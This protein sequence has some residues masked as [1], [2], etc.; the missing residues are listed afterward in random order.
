MSAK[1]TIRGPARVMSVTSRNTGTAGAC[2]EADFEKNFTAVPVATINNRSELVQ[3]FNGI[4]DGLN[5]S[6][7]DWEK[8]VL[9]LKKLRSLINCEAHLMP[10]F[11]A[12]VLS[13]LVIP[14][15]RAMKDL[16]SQVVREAAYTISL[17]CKVFGHKMLR[18][19]EDTF[20]SLLNVVQS[21]AKVMSSSAVILLT[22]IGSYI[23]S[24][25][26][27]TH[28]NVA[29]LHKSREI[30]RA[31]SVMFQ[32]IVE[33]WDSAILVK[34]MGE[35]SSILTRGLNDADPEVRQNARDTFVLFEESYKEVAGRIFKTLDSAKQK[36]MTGRLT[37]S[38]ST[39]S[40]T[41]TIK[42]AARTGIPVSKASSGYG[43]A[44]SEIDAASVRRAI[45]NSTIKTTTL[46]P[47]LPT[48]RLIQP[49]SPAI[50]TP[51]FSHRKPTFSREKSSDLNNLNMKGLSLSSNGEG[52]S[53]IRLSNEASRL[54]QPK[55]T[56]ISSM[57]ISQRKPTHQ[58]SMTR[59]SSSDLN[60]GAYG[61]NRSPY[62]AGRLSQGKTSG[63]SSTHFS[64]RKPTYQV[65]GRESSYDLNGGSSSSTIS[66]NGDGG[67]STTKFSYESAAAFEKDLHE[68]DRVISAIIEDLMPDNS[69]GNKAA[70]AKGLETLAKDNVFKKWDD[71]FKTILLLLVKNFDTTDDTTLMNIAGAFKELVNKQPSRFNDYI[72]LVTK[73]IVAIKGRSERNSKAIDLCAA[74]MAK[75]L[76]A[77]RL[78]NI[79]NTIVD[80]E[81]D[82]YQ[83]SNALKMLAKVFE[84]LPRKDA[85]AFLGTSFPLIVKSYKHPVSTVRRATVLSLVT[86]IRKVER[87]NVEPYLQGL[88]KSQLRLLDVYLEK[89]DSR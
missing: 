80:T 87:V 4:M 8:R 76:E 29:A 3:Y 32:K 52:F 86:I 75:Q 72:E 37:S 84:Y 44:A 85:L 51:H 50:T 49:K 89:I 30:R 23:E 17:Y 41:E 27:L 42:S 1:T 16:R 21:S 81:T 58:Q 39:R 56:P 38:S 82:E 43:R 61:D 40:I 5:A 53:A 2:T 13:K 33:N 63:S 6:D 14:L 62:D 28:M 66:T 65:N 12:E 47:Q 68:Q 77:P 45:K 60:G 10:E 78:L 19:I 71:H 11:D 88:D 48:S 73:A 57:Y 22:Y 20:E 34:Q 46:R 74:A 7:V 18:F 59:E 70:A 26:L 83:L 15:E 64:Q 25:R 69:N 79:L 9:A 55:S 31:I 35:V 24:G 54:S 67:T 36:A